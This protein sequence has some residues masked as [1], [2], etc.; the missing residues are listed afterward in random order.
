MKTRNSKRVKC[1]FS[2][3]SRQWC[4]LIECILIKINIYTKA[5]IQLVIRGIITP[6]LPELV[7]NMRIS[8]AVLK[9]NH[10]PLDLIPRLL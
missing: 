3:I 1:L 4:F 7:R 9:I 8:I 6:C 2:Y 5:Y 10:N